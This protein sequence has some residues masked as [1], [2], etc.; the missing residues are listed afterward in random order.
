MTDRFGSSEKAAEAAAAVPTYAEHSADELYTG[1]SPIP[2]YGTGIPSEG[3]DVEGNTSKIPPT[4]ETYTSPPRNTPYPEAAPSIPE[5]LPSPAASGPLSLTLDKDLIFPNVVPATALY[6]LNYTLNSMGNSITLRRSIRT[7]ERASG[8]PSK[9]VDKDL[10][11]FT[12]PP[13][14]NLLFELEGKRRSTYPG[15]GTI[16]MKSG[17]RGKYWECKFKNKVMLKGRSGK[18]EDGDGKPVAREVNEVTMKSKKGKEK[19]NPSG[20]SEN[21]GLNFEPGIEE[22]MVDLMVAVW[23]TKIWCCETYQSWIPKSSLIEGKAGRERVW[24]N[25][26]N[27]T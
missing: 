3:E 5:H 27:I 25:L 19:E 10:Y 16:Q 22:R 12:R 18:W 7:P 21:P 4:A 9:L 24:G 1:N 23:C 6:S 15:S 13:M 26:G 14:S 2:N 17:L 20:L 8:A 11:S